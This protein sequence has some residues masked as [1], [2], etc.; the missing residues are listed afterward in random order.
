[1]FKTIS[2]YTKST[3][4]ICYGY[5][6]KYFSHDTIPLSLSYSRETI[7]SISNGEKYVCE[8]VQGS[9]VHAKAKQWE[10]RAVL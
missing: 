6:K 1:M 10:K 7:P 5:N 3:D 8:V 9:I 2:D 4:L